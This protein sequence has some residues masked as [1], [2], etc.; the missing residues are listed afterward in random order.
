VIAPALLALAVLA[1][2][3][4]ATVRVASKKFTESVL[5]AELAAELV[6]TTGASVERREELGGTRVVW[7]ALLRGD[8]DIYP[9]YTGTLLREVFGARPAGDEAELARM[10]AA[11]GV[12]M[13]RPIGFQDSYAIGMR[14]ELAARLHVE[15]IS[16]LASHP[17]LR[18]AF[19]DEFMDRADGWPAL[20]SRYHLPQRGVRGL[21]HDIAYRALASGEID[22]TD[23]YTTD[24]EISRYH[25][26]ALADDRKAFPEYQAVFVYRADLERR[27]PRALEAVRRLEG[28]ISAPEMVGMNARVRFDGV[29]SAE[30]AAG[31]LAGKLDV[32]APVNVADV[33]TRLRERTGEHLVLVAISLSIAV[34]VAIPLGIWAARRR[35][36]GRVILGVVGVV[37]TIPSL[38]L[39]VFMLPLLGIGARPAIAA[40]ALYGLLPIVRNTHAGLVGIAPE[41]RESAEALGL[42]R[43]ARLRL[44][45]LPL[46]S[47][48]IL[49]G[50][51]TSAVITVG[52]ATLG[53]LVGAGGY[54]QPILTGIRLAST[55]R[56]LEGAVPAALL[57]LAVQGLF[58]LLERALVPRGLAL[59]SSE[60]PSR[61]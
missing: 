27:A 60:P 22:A 48:S 19:T 7:E 32:H 38:A 30:V 56:I 59:S 16:D 39:L 33:W 40:L 1:P 18:L 34:A 23:L 43:W 4:V 20:R 28:R 41:L 42:S 52:T 46:A 29:S 50:V 61:S 24:A 49:A 45:E 58:D 2:G 26:L 10:L 6:E 55:S 44:V 47:P 35:R 13:T 3:D 17:E 11:K 36:A 51:K 15:T 57:A 37:Q 21:D 9:D 25:L 5:L 31:F 54:G 12:A 14:R 8:V 53:A